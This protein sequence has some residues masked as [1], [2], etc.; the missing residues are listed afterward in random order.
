MVPRGRRRHGDAMK[1]GKTWL[2]VLAVLLAAC[3]TVPIEGEAV[4][5]DACQTIWIRLFEASGSPGIYRLNHD[6]NHRPCAHCAKLAMRYFETG[7]LPPRCPQCGG[8]LTVRPV[9]VAR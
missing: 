6:E 7:E 2:A 1:S 9:N 5:C 3:A 4:E 8:N